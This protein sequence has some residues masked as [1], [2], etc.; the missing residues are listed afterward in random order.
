MH[1]ATWC[2]VGHSGTAGGRYVSTSFSRPVLLLMVTRPA[3]TIRTPVRAT[4]T[5]RIG[6]PITRAAVEFC[7]R[8]SSPLIYPIDRLRGS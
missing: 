2:D 6:T 4:I 5:L 1:A 8:L 3:T 7:L